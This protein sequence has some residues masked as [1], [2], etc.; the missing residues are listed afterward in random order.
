MTV[1]QK[2]KPTEWVRPIHINCTF[3]RH[4]KVRIVGLDK[5]KHNH[6]VCTGNSLFGP[7]I[8]VNKKRVCSWNLVPTNVGEVQEVGANPYTKRVYIHC[9]FG[10]NR[11]LRIP[12]ENLQKV[13]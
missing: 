6:L 11:I 7:H 4:D 10:N 5:L 8:M 13:I 12:P 3:K 9:Y 2:I 1:I